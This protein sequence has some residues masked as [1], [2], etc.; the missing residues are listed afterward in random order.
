MSSLPG[1]L[2][3]SKTEEEICETWKKEDTFRNQNRLSLERNDEVR[4][5]SVSMCNLEHGNNKSLI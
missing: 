2:D 4:E 5:W 1:A 3:F